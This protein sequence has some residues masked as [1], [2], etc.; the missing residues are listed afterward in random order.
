[1][2]E[3]LS[4]LFGVSDAVDTRCIASYESDH[5]RSLCDS[6]GTTNLRSRSLSL[7]RSLS[8]LAM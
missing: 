1:V 3:Y 7:S 4:S 6:F 2:L 5:S 8:M